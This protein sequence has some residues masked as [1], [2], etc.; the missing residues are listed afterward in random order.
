M[1]NHRDRK[2]VMKTLKTTENKLEFSKTTK[3]FFKTCLIGIGLCVAVPL[4]Y[5]IGTNVY[6]LFVFI[7]NGLYDV[8]INPF[9]VPFNEVGVWGNLLKFS[10]YL[11][12]FL[13]LAACGPFG[14]ILGA[15][16]LLVGLCLQLTGAVFFMLLMTPVV[17]YMIVSSFFDT[18]IMGVI[19]ALI[20]IV[21]TIFCWSML[22]VFI[23]NL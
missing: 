21:V 20:T 18:P 4:I 3:I 2:S 17:V 1:K 8:F 7:L 11:L 13:I 15:I 23:L 19:A 5:F 16:I 10:P 9:M 12:A 14:W 6:D 22:T